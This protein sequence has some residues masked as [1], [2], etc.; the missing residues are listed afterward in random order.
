MSDS[1]SWASPGGP[2]PDAPHG[3]PGASPYAPAAQPVS[4]GAS[5]SA[6]FGVVPPSPGW[7]PP[8]K[9][10]LIPLR[11]IE[12]GTVLG[13]SFQ[14]LRRNPRP[15]FGAALLLNAL[16]VFLSSGIST[17]I[18]L[19]GVDR[20]SRASLADADTILAGTVALAVVATLLA[21]GISVVAQALLQG[22]ISVEVSRAT[23]GEKLTLRQLVRVGRGR[24]WALIGWTALVGFAVGLGVAV[25]IA[26]SLGFFIVG[27]PAAIAGGI[28]FLLIGGLG[29][30]VLAAWLSTKLAF[31]P[32]SI[33]IE[34]LPLSGALR[35]SWS[36]V[37]G[38]FWRIFGTLVLI[39]VMVN[40]A[41]S[42]VTTPV[43]FAATF[44]LPL[45]NPAG[46]LET[47][48]SLF[49]ILN[50][51][52][53]AITSVVGAIGAVLTTSATSLLYIDRRM[54]TEGLD[55]EL[56]RYVELRASGA[57]GADPYLTAP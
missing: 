1:T 38:A 54:R 20:A 51:V 53:I 16:V 8:P 33:I 29:F 47:D 5:A 39:T 13:A 45:A 49:I 19:S 44:A 28:V 55:L 7:T 22:I 46:E 34:R 50:L 48:F 10:G 25:L 35:R 21:I 4:Q 18:L 3:A 12:F 23:L 36:L 40:L 37:R 41:A 32:A 6:P 26:L 43:Q 52:V 57:A 17:I 2:T 9:P 27:Q 14:V 31:V 56:Q 24:W 42:I 30:L 11:P 15:T